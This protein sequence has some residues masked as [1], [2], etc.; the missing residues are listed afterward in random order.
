MQWSN[1]L[2][3]SSQVFWAEDLNMQMFLWTPWDP[4]YIDIMQHVQCENNSLIVS[5]AKNSCILIPILNSFSKMMRWSLGFTCAV[6]LSPNNSRILSS[7][8][9]LVMNKKQIHLYAEYQTTYRS[10]YCI[11]CSQCNALSSV[12][13]LCCSHWLLHWH[14]TGCSLV[15]R[16]EN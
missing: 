11:G 3:T 9:F 2:L 13:S 14:L 12:C 7:L 15:N 1:L 5:T 8:G 4:K 6:T 10:S 16:I